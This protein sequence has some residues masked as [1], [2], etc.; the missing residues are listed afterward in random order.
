MDMNRL[1]RFQSGDDDDD[2]GVYVLYGLCDRGRDRGR[3]HGRDRGLH[4]LL[5]ILF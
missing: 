4:G 3:D 5:E 1:C 2:N